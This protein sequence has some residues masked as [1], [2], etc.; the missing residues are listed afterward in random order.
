MNTATLI[1]II[2]AG[3]S[4][5]V[6]VIGLATA[7]ITARNSSKSAKDIERFR[8]NLNLERQSIEEKKKLKSEVLITLNDAI[9]AIQKIKDS[10]QRIVDSNKNSHISEVAMQ[11]IAAA[12]EDLVSCYEERFTELVKGRYSDE[13]LLFHRAKSLAFKIDDHIKFVLNEKENRSDLS[14]EEK[15]FL[16]AW[17]QEL[18]EIQSKLQNSLIE[19]F[20]KNGIK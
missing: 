7:Y 2:T 9:K 12:S 20:I 19:Q 3:A 1:A 6:A 14:A 18:S 11:S 17:R 13:K 8:L 5:I 10:I 15:D 4:L 16:R